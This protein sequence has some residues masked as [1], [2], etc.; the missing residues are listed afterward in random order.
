MSTEDTDRDSASKLS[1][2]TILGRLGATDV[3]LVRVCR[4]L[5][6]LRLAVF[7]PVPEITPGPGGKPGAPDVSVFVTFA[8]EPDVGEAIGRYKGI[9]ELLRQVFNRGA[10]VSSI[11]IL[12]RDL[13]RNVRDRFFGRLVTV[14]DAKEGEPVLAGREVEASSAS[15]TP[16]KPTRRVVDR[17]FAVRTRTDET[18]CLVVEIRYGKRASAVVSEAARIRR[19][20]TRNRWRGLAAA[21]L[22]DDCGLLRRYGKIAG[23]LRG[24]KTPSRNRED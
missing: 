1:R 23:S 20:I 14:F 24:P 10:S 11:E 19:E 21:D 18:G 17:R 5:G 22:D 16:A 9:R 2:E 7:G 13:D 15:E 8:D 6:L 4:T 12:E 3:D